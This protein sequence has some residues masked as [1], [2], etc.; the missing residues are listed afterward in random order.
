MEIAI[1]L[2]LVVLTVVN[3]A[4]EWLAIEVYALLLM[5]TLVAT[6]I[7]TPQQASLGFANSALVMIA[8]V[9]ILTGAIIDNGVADLIALKIRRIA[10]RSERRMGTFLLTAVNALSSVI[11]NVAATAMFIP[12]AEGMARHFRV[13]RSKY[14]M[15]IA[16]ASMTGGMCTLIGTSTN[17]AVSGAL[18]QHGLRPLSFFELSPVGVLVALVGIPYLLLV[19]PKLISRK[20]ELDAIEAYGLRDFLYEILVRDGAPI[21]GLTMS[22]SQLG[23]KLG[24]TVLA[25]TRG[26]QRIL[27]PQPT[28]LIQPGDV[29]LVEGEAGT[30]PSIGATKGLEVRAMAPPDWQGLQAEKVKVMEATVS[31]NSP[32]VGKTLLELDFRRRFN[33]SVLAIHRRERVSVDRVS[34]IPLRAGDVLL[35]YGPEEMFGRLMQEPSML[36]VESSLL[37]KHDR[38]K[39]LVALAVF[40]AAIVVASI[41][42]LDSPMA[43]LTGAGLVMALRALEPDEAGKYLNLRFL[44]M[45]AGM[46]TLGRAMEESGAAEFLAVHLVGAVPGGSHLALFG[47]FFLLTV[48]L[49]QPLSNA[50]AALLVLPIAIAAATRTGADPRA[51]AVG[52]TIAAS[53]SFVTPFEPACLLVYG[54]G[55]YTFRDFWLAGT[56]LTFVAF[57]IALVLVPMLWP[58]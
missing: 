49:T 41:G 36:L 35:I 12:V 52:V 46:A 30:I 28:D 51:F 24:L 23:E 50:A 3:M 31:Y 58:F 53:C 2:A 15:P 9:M 25:I 45:L 20:P 14:L 29:L 40:V 6:G 44:V 55:R 42:W 37:L 11:N 10:G 16:F 17:I 13:S 21:V 7:L 57:L 33:L 8:G 4:R 54:T 47:A 22:H 18:E 48:L 27:A 34:K 38:K 32:F 26:S 39:A 19:T 5:G 56:G 1:V 43:F